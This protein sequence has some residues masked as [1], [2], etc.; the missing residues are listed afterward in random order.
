[1]KR[2]NI[3]LDEAQAVALDELSRARGV[4]RAELVRRILDGA[5][6]VGQ[7][8]TL[9]D[10]LAAIDESFGALREHDDLV[11]RAPDE[12]SLYLERIARQ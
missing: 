7:A 11:V 1:M 6:E 10:D 12:R 9:A 2:T 3:Y 8:G 4:S 5:L